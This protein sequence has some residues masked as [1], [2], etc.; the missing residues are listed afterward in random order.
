[1]T[2]QAQR[3]RRQFHP[4][5]R[6]GWFDPLPQRVVR[7]PG[8]YRPQADS[9][10]LADALREAPMPQDARVLDLCTGSGVL[11]IT[12]AQL[13]AGEVTALDISRRA[14][15][16]AWLNGRLNRQP[17][18]VRHG[19]FYDAFA[20]GTYDVVL[21]NP[22]YVPCRP[23]A[24]TTVKWDA[25]PDGR[26]LL[27]PLCANAIELLRPGGFLLLV[28]SEFAGVDASLRGLRESGLKAAVVARRRLPFG[29]VMRSRA[30]Y[31]NSR[32]L[33]SAE[34]ATEEVVVIRADR[35]IRPN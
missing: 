24:E 18:R 21:A 9:V 20:L 14:V 4:L 17:V 5:L 19:D 23:G 34:A 1:V 6:R 31:L 29:P 22:P 10:L 11:A 32:G 8:V 15:A 2:T 12:A 3:T 26:S 7:L 33:C 13:G 28:H 30:E 25:G 16:S 27:D 35:P